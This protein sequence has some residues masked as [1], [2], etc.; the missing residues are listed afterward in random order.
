MR[1]RKYLELST[2]AH[3]GARSSELKSRLLP[4]VCPCKGVS[5]QNWA[6]LYLSLRIRANLSLPETDQYV[7]MMPAPANDS[8]TAW[9]KRALTSE[10]GAD[11]MRKILDAPKTFDRRI[12]THSF[13]S[14]LISWTAKYGLPDTSRAVLARHLS[15]ATATTAVYSRDLL[16]PVLRELDTML[17]AMRCTL[18]QPDRTR[19]GMVTP[20]VMAKFQAHRSPCRQCLQRLFELVWKRSMHREK[21]QLRLRRTAMEAGLTWRLSV[22]HLQAKQKTEQVQ[23]DHKQEIWK[24]KPLKKTVNRALRTVTWSRSSSGLWWSKILP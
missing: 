23:M 2:R 12:S 8:A 1:N 22:L 3:K 24:A 15:C 11:F 7:P 5:D 16:S 17:Q 13:K 14:T 4:I 18:F 6:V 19:S 20:T 9:Y 10:E 21:L